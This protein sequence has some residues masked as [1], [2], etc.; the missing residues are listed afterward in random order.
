MTFE[1]LEVNNH[2]EC[3]EKIESLASK[4]TNHKDEKV[5]EIANKIKDLC[6]QGKELELLFYL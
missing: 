3:Y 1:K 5:K 2:T 6:R 4:L